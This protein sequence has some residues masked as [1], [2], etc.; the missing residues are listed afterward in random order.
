[1][2]SADEVRESQRAAW[3]GLAQGWERWDAV[4]MRQLQPVS[5]AM[6]EAL[7]VRP[8]QQHLDIASGTGEPGLSVAAQSPLGRVVLTDLSQQMLGVAHRR[9]AL[10]G[11]GRVEVRV[12]SADALPYDVETFDSATIRFGLMFLPDPTIAAAE[13]TRVLRPGGRLAAS[14]WVR[15]ES[16]P[17]TSL[18]MDAVRAEVDLPQAEPDSPSMYRC[19]APGYVAA[20]LERAGLAVALD[21][22]V[23]VDLVTATP[24]EYW[25]M[26][27]QHVSLVVAALAR[28]DEAARARI[29]RAV[30]TQVGKYAGG[31]EVRVPG[32]ARLTVGHKPRR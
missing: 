14:V 1:M 30:V 17:W 3:D 16:N 25:R 27:S 23:A 7:D 13:A 2:P 15:P 31:D 20:L 8:D 10:R 5:D 26:M 12:C 19:A 18:V 28:V 22:E 6:L 21:E 4:I 29:E 9:A 32:L 24:Q 11:L